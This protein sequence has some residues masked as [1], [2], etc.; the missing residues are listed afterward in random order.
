MRAM[1][2]KEFTGTRY[3]ALNLEH[4]FRSLPFL[5]MGIP[6]LYKNSFELIINGGIANAWGGNG[7]RPDG[8]YYEAGIGLNR[9]F[10]LFRVDGTWR[11]SSPGGFTATVGLAQIF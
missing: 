1:D 6:F 8:W 7:S 10:E 3:V 4:N 11:L 5:A 9:I 2:V